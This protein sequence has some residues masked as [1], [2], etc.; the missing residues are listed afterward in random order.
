MEQDLNKMKTLKTITEVLNQSYERQSMLQQVL[1]SFLAITHFEAG[2]IFLGDQKLS[3]VADA[4]LP[5]ALTVDDKRPMCGSKSC[6]CLSRYE[7]HRLNDAIN[8]ITCKRLEDAIASG[9]YDTGGF[10]HHA[11]V[12]LQNE[13]KRFGVFNVTAPQRNEFHSEELELLQSI[14]DQITH[15][16]VRVELFEQEE[17]RGQY[18]QMLHTF[19]AQ[20][21]TMDHIDDFCNVINHKLIDGFPINGCQIESE[22]KDLRIGEE[23]ENLYKIPLNQ[24][25]G[26]VIYFTEHPLSAVDQEILSLASQHIGL[27]I[28][29][30]LIRRREKEMIQLQERETLAQDLHDTVNQLLYS[31]TATS[32][33]LEAM[34]EDPKLSDPLL[35]LKQLSNQALQEMREIIENKKSHMLTHGL[36]SALRQY[37]ESLNIRL[38]IESTGTTS[39]PPYI[40]EALYK[41]GREAIHN[42]YKHAFVNEANIRLEGQENQLVF[43]ISDQGVGMNQSI[44]PK[45][46]GL[47]GIEERIQYLNGILNIDS[48]KGEGVRLTIILPIER[49]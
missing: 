2:W 31:M 10:T 30:M 16:L 26:H 11:T 35:D 37:A 28:R 19:S 9:T 44:Q 48:N 5:E 7:N 49:G 46:F 23:T 38:D 22:W 18:L 42:V 8:I 41:I 36:L 47:K 1:E 43:I 17:K 14:A 39:I 20:L 33:A 6:H 40:E 3:L 15:A 13:H 32:S 21:R 27:T 24:V 45:Q 25:S 29:E 12:P 4:G 34:N